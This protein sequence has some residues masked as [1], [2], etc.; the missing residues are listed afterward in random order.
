MKK[1]LFI[2]RQAP[3]GNS[4]AREALDALLA[5]SAYDQD[6][7]LLFMDEGVF[8][9]LREQNPKAIHQKNLG[10]S[11]QA[12]ELYGIEKIYVHSESL[13]KRGLEKSELSLEDIETLNSEQIK[14]LMVQQDQILSF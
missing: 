10:A 5:A 11:L 4:I 12:L 8:Q 3:Y 9:L 14:Q 13:E 7:S 6:L 1:I 2:S